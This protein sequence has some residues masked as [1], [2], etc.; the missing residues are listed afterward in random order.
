MQNDIKRLP[1][2]F[3]QMSSLKMLVS[4]FILVLEK[5]SH[6]LAQAM[7]YTFVHLPNYM[8]LLVFLVPIESS[9]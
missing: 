9:Q 4:H 6:P 3:V 2:P 7:K 1:R 5:V 8:L